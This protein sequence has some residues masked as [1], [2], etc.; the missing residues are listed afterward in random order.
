MINPN[1]MAQKTNTRHDPI[2]M[3][4]QDH[5]NVK[6]LFKKYRSSKEESEKDEISRHIFAELELHTRIEEEIFYP[7]MERSGQD[8]AEK[9]VAESFVEHS[10][11]KTLIGELRS[12][13]VADTEFEARMKVLMENVE[14][15]IEEEENELFPMAKK[16][17]SSQLEEL[18]S[19]MEEIKKDAVIAI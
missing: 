9:L 12:L 10:Q 14:H 8:K 2:E 1:L 6:D 17:M 11:V 4:K 16:E 3:L 18:G 5:R 7:A 19:E 13:D 15:H